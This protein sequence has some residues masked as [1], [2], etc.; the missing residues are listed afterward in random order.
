M[1]WGRNGNSMEMGIHLRI[2]NESYDQ[3]T[4]SI[5]LKNSCSDHKFIIQST[6]VQFVAFNS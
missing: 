5:F 6:G 1:T 4:S 3:D 2:K